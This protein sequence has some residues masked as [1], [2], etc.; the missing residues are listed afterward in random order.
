ML[1]VLKLSSSGKTRRIYVKRRDLLRANH[2]QPRDLRRIDPSLSITKTSPNISVKEHCLLVNLGGVRCTTACSICTSGLH[3]PLSLPHVYACNKLHYLSM[4][5]AC[6]NLLSAI[7]KTAC[8][9]L[10]LVDKCIKWV[11]E[12]SHALQSNHHSPQLLVV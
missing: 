10:S 3:S 5:R 2:L 7:S 9:D 8:E 1:Q 6:C 11:T 4:I 12:S